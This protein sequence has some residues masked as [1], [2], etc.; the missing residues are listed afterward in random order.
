[1][2]QITVKAGDPIIKDGEIDDTMY[3]LLSGEV[4]VTKRLTLRVSKIEFDERDK[5]IIRMKVESRPFFGEMALFE[6]E[7]I[8]SAAVVAT[9]DST[10]AKISKAN[11]E[12][13]CNADYEMGYMIFR[14]ITGV[15]VDRLNI[16][17]IDVL[18]LTTAF[19]IAL[20]G[21]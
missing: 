14:N 19:S 17:N 12:K 11:F 8:R 7:N 18:K 20:E 4:E 2:K 15:L 13:L 3:I 21:G 6:K 9:E 1:M 10:L 16:E 5:Q